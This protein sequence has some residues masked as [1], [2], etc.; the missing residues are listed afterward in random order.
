MH[1]GLLVCLELLILSGLCHSASSLLTSLCQ[2]LSTKLIPEEGCA[3]E[4]AAAAEKPKPNFKS[5]VRHKGINCTCALWVVCLVS[6]TLSICLL[7][8]A[9]SQTYPDLLP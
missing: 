2:R 4:T 5:A 7:T 1:N 3:A 6:M 8:Q 9:W